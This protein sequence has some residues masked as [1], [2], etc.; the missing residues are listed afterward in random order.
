MSKLFAKGDM[1]QSPQMHGIFGT[2]EDVRPQHRNG[3]GWGQVEYLLRNGSL[4]SWLDENVI[5]PATLEDVVAHYLMLMRRDAE[6]IAELEALV[7]EPD[8]MEDV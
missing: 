7:D 1:V 6:R 2:V 5:E 4:T 3:R 8:D